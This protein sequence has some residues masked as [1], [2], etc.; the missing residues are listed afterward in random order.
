M[1]S[2]FC[3]KLQSIFIISKFCISLLYNF[4]FHCFFIPL[5]ICPLRNHIPFLHFYLQSHFYSSSFF[6]T[7]VSTQTSNFLPSY[8]RISYHFFILFLAYLILL[9][10]L[11]F[12][13]FLIYDFSYFHFLFLSVTASAQV[14]L[15]QFLRLCDEER[16]EV[17]IDGN[18]RHRHLHWRTAH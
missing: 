7:T 15:E 2:S 5:F 16:S 17:E 4:T 14:Y 6:I 3:S 12:L 9:I 1:L 10:F 8:S 13:I 11:I 18:G